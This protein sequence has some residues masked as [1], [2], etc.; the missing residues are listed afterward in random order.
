[1]GKTYSFQENETRV[2]PNQLQVPPLNAL[3][4][5][6]NKQTSYLTME[7]LLTS[8]YVYTYIDKHVHVF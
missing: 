7:P 2:G 3:Y 8:W 4:T 6:T 1:M 5:K